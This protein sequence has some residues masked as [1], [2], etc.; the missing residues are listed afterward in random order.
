METFFWVSKGCSL[1]FGATRRVFQPLFSILDPA[2]LG[3]NKGR[4]N[5]GNLGK[6]GVT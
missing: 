4:V 5:R 3:T 6:V 1:I 2:R